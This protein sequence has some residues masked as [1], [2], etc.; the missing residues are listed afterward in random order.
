MLERPYLNLK[1]NLRSIGMYKLYHDS[2]RIYQALLTRWAGERED[3]EKSRERQEGWEGGRERGRDEEMEAS[4]K[5]P[6]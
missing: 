2:L 3:T 5:T 6:L 4:Q 1:C